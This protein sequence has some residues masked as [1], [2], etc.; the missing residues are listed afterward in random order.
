MGLNSGRLHD[1]VTQGELTTVEAQLS[2]IT[3]T[4]TE[5]DAVWAV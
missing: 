1:A 3:S 2:A 5:A 4:L